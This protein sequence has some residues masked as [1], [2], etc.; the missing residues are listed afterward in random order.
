M[1]LIS[2][3]PTDELEGEIG[4]EEATP[5]E[6]SGT[7]R[8]LQRVFRIR[9]LSVLGAA[10]L[11]FIFLS[12]ATPHFLQLDNLLLVARQISILTIV[13]IGM[14]FLFIAREIDLSVGS[15]YGFLVVFLAT[16]IAKCKQVVGARR[17][18]RT[19][20]RPASRGSSPVTT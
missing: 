6:T 16:L 17:Q 14:T 12:L 15:L 4:D 8:P 3:P 2:H 1:N 20:P 5:P 13:A 18:V 9:E 7:L 11:L 10:A 19:T